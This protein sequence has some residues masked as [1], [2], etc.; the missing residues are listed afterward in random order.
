MSIINEALKKAQRDPVAASSSP[1]ISE[2]RLKTEF[3]EELLGRKRR[4][5]WGPV[6]ILIVLLLIVG[7]ILA[8]L[9]STPFK[10]TA[11]SRPEAPALVS[12]GNAAAQALSEGAPRFDFAHRGPELVEGP[13][14]SPAVRPQFAVEETL[15]APPLFQA[16]TSKTDFILSG[17]V[18]SEK[19]S[20]C[21]VNG[22]VLRIGEAIDGATVVKIASDQVTLN[23]NG[24][25]ITLTTAVA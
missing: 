14:H 24:Q 13:I 25:I 7:P 12:V 11:V 23:A 16:S 15:V 8:P 6:F 19:G 20:Y 18:F 22:K 9:F 1:A 2:L 21:L 4:I 5:N 10:I 17:I 3:K